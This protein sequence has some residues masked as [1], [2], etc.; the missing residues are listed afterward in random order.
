MQAQSLFDEYKH[1][2]GTYSVMSI[3]NII[4]V[5]NHIHQIAGLKRNELGDNDNIYSHPVL[6]YIAPEN[7]STTLP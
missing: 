2:F 3:M 1:L 7:N 6:K 4:T 5:L